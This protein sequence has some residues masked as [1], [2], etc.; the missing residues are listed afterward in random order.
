M[1]THQH[2]ER[3]KHYT[4]YNI[5]LLV[6]LITL[7]CGEAF[8]GFHVYNYSMQRKQLKEDYSL[9]NNVTFGLFSVDQ[10]RDRISEVIDNQVD[11][12]HITAKQKK[13]MQMAI[14][15]QLHTLVDKTVLEINK[16]QKSLGG[17]LKKLAFN[18][19]VDSGEIQAQVRP[20]AKTIVAKIASPK[21]QER[22][23]S[24][25]ASKIDQLEKQTYDNT[26]EANYS[27][28][29]HLYAKYHVDD[30]VKF[31]DVINTKLA[32]AHKLTVT[33]VI[34]M[35][36]CVLLALV[37]WWLMRKQVYLQSVLFV[38]SLAFA[39][40]LL[41]V[42]LT[43]SVIE[44]DARIKTL[45]FMLLDGKIE[46]KNQVLFF[47]SK[48]ILGIVDTLIDQPKPDA[49]VVGVLVLLFVILLPLL[50]L[51]ASG[52]HVLSSRK[53]AQSGVVRYLAFES[54]KWDM[55]DVMIV[56][57]L[58]TF[59]GLNGI[60][61]SQLSNLNMHS[62]SLICETSNGTSIQPGYFVFA[63]YVL[64]TFLLSYILKRISPPTEKS[65][66]KDSAILI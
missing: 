29:K 65:S 60:L 40:V 15:K 5:V 50:R 46:F 27:V 34:I 41:V 22:L 43:T 58:M 56:G 26:A 54:S 49:I 19:L 14:E 6:G 3:P 18:A 44:V 37:L 38:L 42:G 13:A 23:K 30:P 25:A 62:G 53:I 52:I 16:P 12:Y 35:F 61:K 64:F 66:D 28:T 20:F 2:K 17:K 31:N 63:G 55:S 24:I 10:W 51:T 1:T 47:Q 7:L 4:I 59:I 45:H 11:E 33:Y 39:F 21:S 57:M 8:T 9:S 32:E 36:G 48:S